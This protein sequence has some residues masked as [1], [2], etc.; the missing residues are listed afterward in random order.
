MTA[1]TPRTQP[2]QATQQ[3]P[4]LTF[5]RSRFL[6]RILAVMILVAGWGWDNG[7]F[8]QPLN[9]SWGPLADALHLVPILV[10]L[11]LGMRIIGA[12]LSDARSRGAE[13]GVTVIALITVVGN[14]VMIALGATNPDPNS[15][16]VHT[17]EDW[18][19]AIVMLMGA[20]LWL[21]TLLIGRRCGPLGAE[22]RMEN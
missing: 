4:I 22:T 16:G 9:S 17:A 6:T 20:L 15:V 5:D 8:V 2:S 3:A 10:L 19:P 1:S 13:I 21:G 11:P 18:M 12:A 14:I 7:Q